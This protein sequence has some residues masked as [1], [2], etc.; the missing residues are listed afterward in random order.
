MTKTA[1]TANITSTLQSATVAD[2]DV[3]PQRIT[4]T[5][6]PSKAVQRGGE[7]NVKRVAEAE[8]LE[9][10][11]GGD[12]LV[13]PEFVISKRRGLFSTKITS[14]T[15]SGRPANY[16]NIRSFNDSVWCNPVFRGIMESRKVADINPL[17]PEAVMPKLEK[18][19]APVKKT[20]WMIRVG[21]GSNK[22]VGSENEEMDIHR[23]AGYS[24]G[25][26]FNRTIKQ[27]GAYWGMDFTFANRGY[28][29]ESPYG[30]YKEKL[31]AHYFQWTPFIFGWKIKVGHSNFS[32]DPH[33]GVFASFDMAGGIEATYEHTYP[34]QEAQWVPGYSYGYTNYPGHY[35]YNTT[36]QTRTETYEGSV[37]DAD[38]GDHFDVG[39]KF[40]V[41][42]WYKNKYN[43][44]FTVQRGFIE[45]N[46]GSVNDGGSLNLM[47]RLG[48]AF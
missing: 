7:A 45:P 21:V 46:Y 37:Y 18:E 36:Y 15:V 38:G 33:I 16:T 17:M 4:Y 14:I 5:M 23:K 2:L 24:I 40:G 35:V 48:Y 42:V 13:N 3:A 8:A 22:F 32:I 1:S 10:N 41:G 12:L 11:G 20:T 27:K 29:I 39:L 25:F 19:Y 6:T 44:D 28:E 47:F 9:K 34:T 26:E 43:V 30:D 31:N